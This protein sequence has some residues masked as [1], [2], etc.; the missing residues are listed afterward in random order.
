M[1]LIIITGILTLGIIPLLALQGWAVDYVLE[2]F[3]LAGVENTYW[4][5]V[6]LGLAIDIVIGIIKDIFK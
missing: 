3:G 5:Y 4:W 2:L 6:L 1:A